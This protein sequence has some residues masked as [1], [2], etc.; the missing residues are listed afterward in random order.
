MGFVGRCDVLGEVILIIFNFFSW[1]LMSLL[2]SAFRKST[3]AVAVVVCSHNFTWVSYLVQYACRKMK[4]KLQQPIQPVEWLRIVPLATSVAFGICTKQKFSLLFSNS[5]LDNDQLAN[6][7]S[8]PQVNRSANTDG[9][10]VQPQISLD[11]GIVDEAGRAPIELV[12]TFTEVSVLRALVCAF[13]LSLSLR[14]QPK[15]KK[16]KKNC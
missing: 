12:A 13:T 7:S 8:P 14:S 1:I 16:Q 4:S 9:G 15:T 2:I 3:T 6:V 5:I 11:F 10:V